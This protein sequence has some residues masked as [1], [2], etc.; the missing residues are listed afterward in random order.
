MH[1]LNKKA[2]WLLLAAGVLG[3]NLSA[4]AQS[5]Y[6]IR[7]QPTAVTTQVSPYAYPGQALQNG[8]VV[9][10]YALKANA[11]AVQQKPTAK[12][13][14]KPVGTT[15]PAQAAIKVEAKPAVSASNVLQPAKDVSK[16]APTTETSIV[17]SIPAIN[18]KP[19]AKA[20]VAP[21]PTVTT[22]PAIP[23]A[24]TVV[25]K[26]APL[27]ATK[28]IVD[29]PQSPTTTRLVPVAA[30]QAVPKQIP[31]TPFVVPASIVPG[32]IAVEAVATT[33][34]LAAPVMDN[35]LVATPRISID[36]LM[37][38]RN[39]TTAGGAITAE[40]TARLAQMQVSL[41]WLADPI[42][43]PCPL[44][45]VVS[46]T[47]IDV[48][49]T[50]PSSA[51]RDHAL[52]L[53]ELH[54]KRSVVNSLKVLAGNYYQA[55]SGKPD[56]L[57]RDAADFLAKLNVHELKVRAVANG[58]M[59]VHGTVASYE[60]KLAVSQRLQ[61]L[62]GVTCVDNQITVQSLPYE[63]RNYQLVSAD[64]RYI[65]Q[66]AS[67]PASRAIAARPTQSPAGDTGR[68]VPVAMPAAGAAAASIVPTSASQ[69][70]KPADQTALTGRFAPPPQV[71]IIE[72][73]NV[74]TSE[75]RGFGAR[76]K[77]LLHPETKPVVISSTVTIPDTAAKSKGTVTWIK[78]AQNEAAPSIILPTKVE[79]D[80]SCPCKK[81]DNPVTLSNGQKIYPVN[82]DPAA[83]LAP[84]AA[85]QPSRFEIPVH[86]AG[87]KDK[88]GNGRVTTSTRYD[89]D[90]VK[91]TMGG[92]KSNVML[93][94]TS[95]T[96]PPEGV[97]KSPQAVVLKPAQQPVVTSGV[98]VMSSDDEVGNI[99][100][101]VASHGLESMLKQRLQ[102]ACG[103]DGKDLQV[104]IPSTGN[105][106]VH[107]TAKDAAAAKRLTEAIMKVTEMEAY[108]VSLKVHTLP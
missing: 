90:A 98:I 31:A 37:Q 51:A 36:R 73:N 78:S 81:S 65:V 56:Q 101:T 41:A 66:D 16:P 8:V 99:I 23:A 103:S 1:S 107:V 93:T 108:K 92:K 105:V 102:R 85:K 25:V 57:Q 38:F 95:G 59:V 20:P 77:G 35:P 27:P 89:Y 68:L 22:P 5:P 12:V 24:P 4:L 18:V 94:S 91:G 43:Y 53:A 83:R 79:A 67:A 48:R 28:P 47:M 71:T 82:A 80:A 14:A 61:S 21:Q 100:P 50:V 97:G 7:T 49:G 62:K 39:R 55:P 72:S 64:G 26:P 40:D 58:Q 54:G 11:G 30:V 42:T 86:V 33:V 96:T 106:V 10:P 45:C 9:S 52:G 60:D 46:A 34:A 69:T 74:A 75:P 6:T 88:D 104:T 32:P 87:A 63:G 15:T 29:T 13:E 19:L 44:K 17:S 84:A 70:T 2:R 76:L 3:L